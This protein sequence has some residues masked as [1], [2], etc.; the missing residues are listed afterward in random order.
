MQIINGS[1]TTSLSTNSRK[2]PFA[3]GQD[4]D[5]VYFYVF[6]KKVYP[7]QRS[8]HPR[9]ISGRTLQAKSNTAKSRRLRLASNKSGFQPAKTQTQTQTQTQTK[10]EG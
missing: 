8:I 9:V 3:P 5:G 2:N 7:P 10:K 1:N 4:K 6:H